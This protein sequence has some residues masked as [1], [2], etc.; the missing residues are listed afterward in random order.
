MSNLGSWKIDDLL[1]WSVNTHTPS[2]GA[3][4]DADTVPAYR[5]YED[6]TAT[7]ILTG[8]MALL[9]SVNTVGLYSEQI[10]L[11]AANGFEKGRSYNIYVSA[12]VGGVTGTISH[13]LQME[14]E[15]DA[16]IVSDKT[17]YSVGTGGIVAGSFAAGAVDA[18]ALNA[19][20][21]TEIRDAVTGGAYALD[22][23]ANGRMRVVD[24]TAA[25]EIDTVSGRVQV[26]DAQIA[27]FVDENWDEVLSGA[28]HNVPSSSGRRLRQIQEAGVYSNGAIYIDTINGTA[29]TV[30]F[31]N[32]VETNPVSNIADANTLAASL[33]ISKF[34]IAPV[35]SI[36]LAAS[37]QN[38][39]F[40]GDRWTL[41]LG[42]Q[43]IDN[44]TFIG[45]SVSGVAI[46]STGKQYFVDCEMGAVTI[47]GDTHFLGCGIAGTQTIGEAGDVFYDLCHS[48]IA[49]VGTPSLDAGAAIAGSSI[50]FRHYSGGIEIQNLGVSGTDNMSLEG[51]GQLIINANCT[52]GTIAIRGHFTVTDNAGGAVTLSDD[53]RIDATQIANATWDELLTGASHNIASSAGRR[54]R[55]LQESRYEGGAVWIDTVNG[56]A[57][58][59]DYENGTVQSPSDTVADANTIAASVGLSRFRI[60]PGSTVTFAAA[61]QGQ[62]FLGSGWTLALGGQDI[63]NT[64]IQ[65]ATVT[66]TGVGAGTQFFVDCEMAAVTL[67]A[68]THVITSGIAGTQTLVAGDFFY[69]RC[70]SSIAGTG[71]PIWDFGAAALNTNLNIRNYSGGVD[72]RNMGQAGTDNA[73][74]EGRGQII[75]NANST[76][77][78]MVIRGLF[79]LTDNGAVTI[80]KSAMFQHGVDLDNILADTN[81]LQADW[82]NA[83]RLD[84]ILDARASQATVDAIETDTQDIQGRLPATL[85]SGKMDSDTVAI[86][87]STLAA[88]KLEASALTIIAAAAAAGTLSTTQMTTDLT[89]A[90]DD[91]YNGRI[92]IW[93]SGALIG[94]ASDITDYAGSNFMLTYTATTEAPIATDTFIIV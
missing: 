5:V 53:A 69:A 78:T 10:T 6:E 26:P 25:G 14:A 70:N 81:E 59:A 9:D 85:V 38:Q 91:H 12:A 31:E 76:G 40:S 20:A 17:N 87:G 36:T 44:S 43:N 4:A 49:G 51:D 93:T 33:G 27:Q 82:A 7:P 92:I 11:S 56:T 37:H 47:P 90:T 15:V 88:D 16:N 1:T 30:N 19:D 8:N 60:A 21:A 83:G 62:A 61:Q 45:A 23:D 48:A 65:G 13:N 24:G 80:T 2:T 77:G 32:G 75:V 86:S 39:V 35:S 34:I 94:Q 63:A 71:A 89:E 18:A 84:S 58:T 22:T 66:G 79:D 74:I 28:T 73:S 68:E 3:G 52:G 72:V 55:S 46:N 29:G 64:L 41:A 54:L 57:G 67:P 50:N 42:G